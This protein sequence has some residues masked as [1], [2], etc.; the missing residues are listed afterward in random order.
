MPSVLSCAVLFCSELSG[1][2]GQTAGPIGLK[3]GTT[4][5]CDYAMK[6]VGRCARSTHLRRP[7]RVRSERMS[8]KHESTGMEQGGA[9]DANAKRN[10]AGQPPRARSAS[11]WQ[12]QLSKHECAARA[13]ACSEVQ[14]KR[15]KVV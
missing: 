15:R 2:G 13:A 9:A 12:A 3:I 4:T 6:R 11:M 1:I 7:A 8:A 14:K 10:W 5:H